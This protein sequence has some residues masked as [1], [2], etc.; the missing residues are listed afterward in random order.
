MKPLDSNTSFIDQVLASITPAQQHRTDNRML[1]AA[2]IDDAMQ[3]KNISQ[4]ELA[5]R[6]D[7]HHSVVTLWLSGTQNF[8]IDTLSDIETALGI[9]LFQTIEPQ[10]IVIEFHFVVEQKISPVG[11]YHLSDSEPIS[12]NSFSLSNTKT[13]KERAR[14]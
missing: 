13:P 12:R 9:N 3:E 4:K 2:R 1:I 7:K 6:L 5:K 10:P 8:T 11:A 14:A